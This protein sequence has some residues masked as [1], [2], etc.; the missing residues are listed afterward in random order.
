LLYDVI[1]YNKDITMD[2]CLNCNKE[3]KNYQKKFCSKGCGTSFRNRNTHRHPWNYKLTKETDNRVAKTAETRHV[4]YRGYKKLS[5]KSIFCKNCGV[6]IIVPETS[7]RIF[8]SHSCVTDNSWKT[9]REKR[10]KWI[11]EDPE[12]KAEHDRKVGLAQ[13]GISEKDWAKKQTSEIMK[14]YYIDH[15]EKITVA[16][17][18]QKRWEDPEQHKL[19]GE[20]MK[21]RWS[22]IEYKNRVISKTMSSCGKSFNEKERILFNVVEELFPDEFE[23]VGNGKIMIGG[24]CPDI[25]NK[26]GQKQIIELFG[27]YWHGCLTCFPELKDKDNSVERIEY[28]KKCGYNTLIIWEHELKLDN[29]DNLINKIINF[30]KEVNT[31][32]LA[33]RS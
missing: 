8:C 26:N 23:Y 2:K 15:P 18:L 31:C 10:L 9:T 5:R 33:A 28:F 21:R 6:E 17:A 3:L 19:A 11:I 27:C 12:K 13:K 16:I 30:V 25:I 32:Q 22:D 14:K 29:K 20:E 1:V 7:D 24:K 4:N